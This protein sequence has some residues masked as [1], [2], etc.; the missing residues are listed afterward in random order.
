MNTQ[1]DP[2]QDSIEARLKRATHQ[3]LAEIATRCRQRV[4]ELSVQLPRA[5]GPER[6]RFF[7]EMEFERWLGDGCEEDL[8]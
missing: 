1:N 4:R 6:E 8:L 2:L 5:C 7:A 3:C